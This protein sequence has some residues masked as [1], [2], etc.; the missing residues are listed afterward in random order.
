MINNG[1]NGLEI[2]AGV[3]LTTASVWDD[4]DIVHVVSEGIFVQNMQ[5]EGGLR[6]Q[7]AP[8]ESLVVKFDGYGSNFNPNIG[9]GLTA[10]GQL[11]S[12]DRVG[13]TLHV[14]GQPGFPVILT[15][16]HDDTVGA[17]LQPDGKPQTDT[18]N[19]GIGSTPRPSDWRGLFLDQYSNDRNVLIAMESESAT[20]AAPGPNGQTSTAQS[21]GSLAPRQTAG[22]ENL[23]L[24]FTV[25]GVLSQSAD[26]DVFSFTAEAGTE[27]WIDVDQTRSNLDLVLDLLDTQGNLLAQSNNSTAETVDPNLLVRTAAINPSAVNPMPTRTSNIRLTA[28]GLAKEDGTTNVLDPGM[29]VRLP[30]N[31]GSRSTFYF[32]IRSVGLDVTNA[33]SGLTSGAYQVQVRLQEAQEFA[34]SVINYADI[35]YAMNGVHLRGLPTSS[36]LMGEAAE[37]ETTL[38]QL[39]F[40]RLPRTM[41][42]RWVDGARQSTAIHRKHPQHSQWRD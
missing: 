18:N 37:D 11:N 35:R 34:G 13:G 39:S 12:G 2:R 25:E 15:S 38:N 10:S 20:A 5:H 8:N 9:A 21:L 28:S 36:P 40:T 33:S 26:V 31:P 19:N 17:G 7:S 1:L 27:I 6:L 32:R 42:Q 14:L 22:N 16:I 4:T 29:R 23:R 24:G 41:V 30:G 3:I